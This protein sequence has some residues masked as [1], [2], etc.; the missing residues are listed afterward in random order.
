MKA[1]LFIALKIIELAGL[2][3]VY[4]GFC[5]LGWLFDINISDNPVGFVWYNPFYCL[6]PITAIL[7]FMAIVAF[8]IW[9]IIEAIPWWIESNKNL[10]NKILNK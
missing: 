9:L 8:I 1:L 3:G 10:V 4:L 5:R 6:I 7:V 2:V